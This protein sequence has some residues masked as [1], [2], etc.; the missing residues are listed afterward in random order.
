MSVTIGTV[1]LLFFLFQIKHMFADYFLQTPFMLSGR[2][3]Y[4]HM[5]RALHAGVHAVG[6]AIVLLIV[7]T[8][9]AFLL[10]LIALEWFIHFNIDY[11]KAHYSD[12]MELQPNQA[13]Y[14]HAV[15]F[16]QFLHQMTYVA[17]V[18]AWLTFAT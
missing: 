1:I 17:M 11:G 3:E 5:G 7:G 8:P 9:L 10:L 15:G 4:W 16:D 12:K 18:W 14:W 6:S 2:G 13:R